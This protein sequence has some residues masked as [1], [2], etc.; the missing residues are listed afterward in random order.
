MEKFTLNLINELGL[1]ARASAKFVAIASRFQSKIEVTLSKQTVNGKSI[2]GI[3]TLGARCGST[4]E[5]IAEG[6]DEQVLKEAL[7]TLVN[8]KFDE[9]N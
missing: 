5:C 1:H 8:N 9:E 3:M 7:I 6:P 2:M 4:L